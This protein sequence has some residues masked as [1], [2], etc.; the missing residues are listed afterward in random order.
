[1]DLAVYGYHDGSVC[2]KD[3]GKYYIYEAER[4]FGRRYSL[5]TREFAQE[6]NVEFLT[7]T[8]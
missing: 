7:P 4:F 5:I 3:D 6:E 8:E 1:M 2:V